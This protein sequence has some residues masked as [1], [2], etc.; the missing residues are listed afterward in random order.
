MYW[1]QSSETYGA[2]D[3]KFSIHFRNKMNVPEFLKNPG[4]SFG[5]A[6]MAGDIDIEG[7]I[8]DVITTAYGN[9]EKIW[10]NTLSK[11][12]KFKLSM[13]KQKENVQY[14]YDL[15]ND[16]YQLWLD[17]S[18]SYSC[19]YF[20]A[21]EDTL[22]QAQ[23]QKM[24]HVLRKLQL[25][26]GER[27]LDIGS[28]WGW[29]LIR[30]AQQYGVQAKGITLSEEQYKKSLERIH[31]LGLQDQVEVELI[32][33]RQLSARE[34]RFDKIASVGMFEHVGRDHYP[35]FMSTV[36]QLLKPGG[37]ALLHTITHQTEEPADPWIEKYIF[38]GGYIP[39]I[40]E[41]VSLLPDYQFHLLDV[42]NLRMHYAKTLDIW[43]D[44][45]EQNVNRI[46]EMYGDRFVRMWRL[47][48]QSSAATFRYGGI[49]IHQFLFSKG[50]NNDLSLT[51]EHLYR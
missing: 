8:E 48:L 17:E 6:Y 16:F 27:L 23:L 37:L 19:A 49:S 20:H 21:E 5:E 15:G 24:D 11:L 10:G 1:D 46:Q 38:P 50:V 35:P 22:E 39:S 25:K 13:G 9:R 18:M 32:D 45:F 26:P 29:L 47:Y 30:A 28:G 51:R 33:Y 3:P 4:L 7:R 31:Q 2:E 41:I 14:H 42:E 36:A 34:Q 12:P 44:R 43:A 40:R